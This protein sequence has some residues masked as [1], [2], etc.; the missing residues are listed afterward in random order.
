MCHICSNISSFENVVS[1]QEDYLTDYSAELR[2]KF[3]EKEG[4]KQEEVWQ[5][6]NVFITPDFLWHL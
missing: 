3:G 2:R 1:E 5:V 4:G 6:L